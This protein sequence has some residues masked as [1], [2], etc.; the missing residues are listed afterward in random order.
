MSNFN[1]AVMTD[2]G[3]ALLA[4]ATAGTI[5][6]QFT[7][8]VT[9]DGTYSQQEQE[10]AYLQQ[11]TALKSQKQSFAFSSVATQSPSSVLMKALISNT[12]LQAGYYIREMG[13]YAKASDAAG[14]GILYSIAIAITADYMPPYNGQYPSEIEQEYLA[15]VSDSATVTI[16]LNSSAVALASDLAAKADKSMI[17]T[18]MAEVEVATSDEAIAGALAVKELYQ[19]LD[20][21]TSAGEKGI[22]TGR[23]LPYTWAEIQTK[24]NNGDFEGINIGDYKTIQLTTTETVI[25]EVAGINLYVDSVKYPQYHIDWISRD[26]LN[27]YRQVNATDTNTGGWAA[28]ALRTLMNGTVYDTLPADLKAVISEKEHLSSSKG[29]WAWITDKLWLPTEIEVFGFPSWSEVGCGT[30]GYLQYPIFRRGYRYITKRKGNG[31]SVCNWWLSSP[32]AGDTTYFCRV[33]YDG[34]V[35]YLNA[36]G[37]YGVPLC[38]RIKKVS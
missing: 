23:E 31:G 8:L 24:I 22:R 27:D 25:M 34:G 10:R 35:D 26:C 11:R 28:S 38:F 19:D 36:S 16:N 12:D 1:A 29:S 7:K 18:S 21:F 20:G 5:T 37:A 6:M 9:G 32:N 30:G 17:L 2:A 14:D 15:T 13:I 4:Q 3:A 33:S